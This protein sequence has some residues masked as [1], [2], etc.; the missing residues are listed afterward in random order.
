[1]VRALLVV[2]LL[3]STAG[4]QPVA[5][6]GDDPV[7]TQMLDPSVTAALIGPFVV[8]G[9]DPDDTV[10]V[11]DGF[12]VP[13]VLHVDGV[14][15]IAPAWGLRRIE[16]SPESGVGRSESSTL[17]LTLG[18]ATTRWLADA[19][20]FD[21]GLRH[22]AGQT[23]AVLRYSLPTVPGEREYWDGYLRVS[24]QE[25]PWRVLASMFSTD[26]FS[27]ATGAIG[28][29]RARF[30]V[31]SLFLEEEFATFDTRAEWRGDS[32]RIGEQTTAT[33]DKLDVGVWGEVDQRLDT[34]IVVRAGVR[35]DHFGDGI[36]LAVQP[37]ATLSVGRLALGAGAYRRAVAA[38]LEP[39][40]TT[41]LTARYVHRYLTA[42]AYYQDKRRLVVGATND[43]SGTAYGLEL[44]AQGRAG[45]WFLAG[46]ASLSRSW[47]QDFPRDRERPSDFDQPVRVHAVA[48]RQH[49]RWSFG[50]RISLASGL[51]T[52]EVQQAIYDADRDIYEP[53]LGPV[54][55]E[56]LPF[57]HELALRI[58]R[59]FRTLD[60]HAFVDVMVSASTVS[61]EYSYDFKTRTDVTLPVL[62]YAGL[63]GTL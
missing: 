56:R 33:R 19:N 13:Y 38:D 25:G 60:L 31:S 17:D 58:E 27:R 55:A 26:R 15:G 16:L 20:T 3:T 43:G 36:G 6:T 32:W 34:S 41:Q 9:G 42:T 30:A 5:G 51:P 21:V 61:Y 14:R 47:R 24:Q 35:V 29:D 39:V 8:R 48:A 46:A 62:P 44:M 22:A 18:G 40:R 37:R 54:N 52:T 4:A 53:I 59:T 63:R 28:Y 23:M 12:E 2:A 7:R 1:M 49:G 10:L 50:G 11:V 45:A 57:R